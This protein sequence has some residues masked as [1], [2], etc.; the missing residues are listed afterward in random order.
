MQA[1]YKK[2]RGGVVHKGKK[3]DQKALAYEAG[4]IG[5]GGQEEEQQ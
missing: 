1:N 2:L 5:L 4:M 3:G